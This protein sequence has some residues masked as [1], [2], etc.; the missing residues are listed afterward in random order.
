MLRVPARVACVGHRLGNWLPSCFD[1]FLQP[2]A[3]LRRSRGELAWTAFLAASIRCKPGR[4][5]GSEGCPHGAPEARLYLARHGKTAKPQATKSFPESRRDD[6]RVIV[7][8]MPLG[9]TAGGPY[10]VG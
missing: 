2:P 1:T 4:R 8:P 5:V 3:A 9:M 10:R 6:W 7:S